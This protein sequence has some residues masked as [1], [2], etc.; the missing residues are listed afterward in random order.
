M[1]E[2][3]DLPTTNLDA[4]E[5]RRLRHLIERAVKTS[6]SAFDAAT[7]MA[8]P[9]R[10]QQLGMAMACLDQLANAVIHAHAVDE[11]RAGIMLEMHAA[12]VGRLLAERYGI[13][14][15]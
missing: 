11:G 13:K 4:A 12:N 6:A 5:R 8:G 14:P 9:S 2:L 1:T 3:P 7:R 10:P 15:Q